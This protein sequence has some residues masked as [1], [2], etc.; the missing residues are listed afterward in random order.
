M[1]SDE[2]VAV[3]SRSFSKNPLLRR[4]LLEHY[5][6]VT[7][8][9][10]GLTLDGQNLIN[11]LRGHQ[12]A[13]VA[14]EIIDEELLAHLPDLKVVSKYGVGLDKVDLQALHRYGVR[15]GWTG[16][17]NR[18]SV[19]EMVISVAVVMLRH[20]SIANTE[21]VKG[22]WRQHVGGLLSGRT[23]GVIGCG[24]VGKDLITLLQPWNCK[25][26]AHDILN[27]QD[28]YYENNVQP[29]S[30]EA[31]LSR[32]DVVTL[33]LPLTESTQNI[34]CSKKLRLLKQNA[35]LINFARGGLIDEVEVK[36]M[37]KKGEL[38]GAAFDVFETEPPVDVELLNLPNFF[39]TPHIG[40][41]AIEAILEMGRS[42]IAG[43]E[44]NAVPKGEC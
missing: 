11:F 7:F 36:S 30:L 22:V 31:L 35:I 39:G 42:A 41:S 17:V 25:L 9:D 15:L 8:N 27:F 1:K 14:L 34:L 12:K 19:S 20:M 13:I 37:L 40:G 23:I 10:H 4:E 28:F 32:S 3:C 18:R 21:V 33:H 5:D 6:Y 38:A 16:G 24:F 43:L 26:L 44:E 2:K 29:V